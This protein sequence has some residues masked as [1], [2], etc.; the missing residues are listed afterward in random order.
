MEL[1]ELFNLCIKSGCLP[2]EFKY[3]VV[4]P[5]YKGKGDDN[6]LDNYRGIS[7]LPPIAKV[8]EKIIS[9]RL[10]YYFENNNLFFSNQHGFR[11]NHS[12]ETAL[13]SIIDRWKS[14]MNK[15][16]INLALFIDFKKAFDLVNPKLLIIKLITVLIMKR[17]IFSLTTS[18]TVYK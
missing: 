7:V 3:A 8:F 13:L 2:D 17:S 18:K 9:K 5:L 15:N 6:L 4:T 10:I 12:C 11:S 16:H 14:N 1:N